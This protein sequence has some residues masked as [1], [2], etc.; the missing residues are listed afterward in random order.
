MNRK[1][2]LVNNAFVH[3]SIILRNHHILTI[4]VSLASTKGSSI[5]FLA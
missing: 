4:I 2:E 5:I 3:G 1:H